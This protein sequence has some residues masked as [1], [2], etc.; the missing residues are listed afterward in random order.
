M[1]KIHISVAEYSGVLPSA[2]HNSDKQQRKTAT[3]S[4]YGHNQKAF[5]DCINK[6][7]T[8]LYEYRAYERQQAIIW[9]AFNSITNSIN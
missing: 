7:F 3:F 6:Y 1:T 4:D 5:I 2:K 9:T 8:E